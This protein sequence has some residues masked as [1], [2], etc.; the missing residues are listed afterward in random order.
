VRARLTRYLV[1]ALTVAAV[2][3]AALADGNYPM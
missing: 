2:V 1:V 3:A